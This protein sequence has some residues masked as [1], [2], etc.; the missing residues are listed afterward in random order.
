MLFTFCI[1]RTTHM[2]MKTCQPSIKQRI[3]QWGRKGT[4]WKDPSL[5]K[6]KIF[7]RRWTT[8]GI[9]INQILEPPPPKS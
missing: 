8:N 2:M 3:Q 1:V 6:Q 4:R 7:Q 5:G 9:K